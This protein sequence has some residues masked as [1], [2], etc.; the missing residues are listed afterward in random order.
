MTTLA[1]TDDGGLTAMVRLA[2]AGD[3]AAFDHLVAVHSADMA[4]VAYLICGDLGMSQDAV[5]AAWTIAWRKLGS[6]RDAERHRAWLMTIVANEAR[7]LAGAR[8]KREVHE[9]AIEDVDPLDPRDA[10]GRVELLDVRNALG[11]LA[12]EDRAL[13]ALRY[14]AGFDSTELAAATGR[15]ASGT[16]ARLARLLDRLRVELRDA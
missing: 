13:L 5:Q 1:S 15:T 9:I 12:P 16:R 3:A 6:L 11:R 2:A 8:R 7:H 4:R 14:L 10:P